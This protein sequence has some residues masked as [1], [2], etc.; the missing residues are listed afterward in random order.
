[1]QMEALRKLF[2][3]QNVEKKLL[4]IQPTGHGKSHVIFMQ[5]ILLQGVHWILVS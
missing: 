2:S 3:P 4:V 5:G 1:M